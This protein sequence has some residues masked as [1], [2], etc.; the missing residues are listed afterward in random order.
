MRTSAGYPAP[1]DHLVH[2]AL[3][4]LAVVIGTWVAIVTI[5]ACVGT[6]SSLT[7]WLKT[8]PIERAVCVLCAALS[9]ARDR[10]RFTLTIGGTPG[11]RAG[12]FAGA[13]F[14]GVDAALVL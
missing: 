4:R 13:R 1:R 7:E 6:C 5:H 14:E 10:H 12:I 2:A 8:G 9:A 3:V 11:E